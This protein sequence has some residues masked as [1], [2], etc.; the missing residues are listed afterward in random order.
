MLK[1][2]TN[3]L[4]INPASVG[5][6][7]RRLIKDYVQKCGASGVVLEVSGEIDSCTAAVLA[8]ES[9]GSENVLGVVLLEE[10][11]LDPIGVQ[12]S[13]L[14]ADKFAFKLEVV[15]ISSALNACSHALPI[16]N[17][18]DKVSN[19][20]LR[21]RIKMGLIYYYANRLKRVVC[22]SLNKSETMMGYFTKWGDIA[23]DIAPLMDI[24]RTQVRHLAAFFNIPV[25][26]ISKQSTPLWLN[27]LA[28]GKNSLK[29]EM[30]D[31]ALYGL[32]R[33]MTPTEISGQLGLPFEL[34]N[35]LRKRWLAAEHKRRIPLSA[36][37]GFRTVGADFR[38]PFIAH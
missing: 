5:A 1:L 15:G 14:V 13:R 22:S 19:E 35:S 3:L 34:V 25:E 4:R 6:R 24:Y 17:P 31:L 23:S 36:K 10:G 12:H 8:A 2:T 20:D 29:Y 37:L 27:Q 30:L 26:I 11:T 33:F 7:I 16:W 18:S 38:L 32:E 28:E 21:A 9:L